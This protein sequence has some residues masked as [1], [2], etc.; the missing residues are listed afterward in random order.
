MF[1]Q[2]FILLLKK[3]VNFVIYCPLE[4]AIVLD[5]LMSLPEELSLLD[6]NQLHKHLIQVKLRTNHF[7]NFFWSNSL[8]VQVPHEL[9]YF[10][11]I[12]LITGTRTR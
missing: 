12:K 5:L 8:Q 6:C 7:L 1:L 9:N 10:A 4:S 2:L 3:K 11:R